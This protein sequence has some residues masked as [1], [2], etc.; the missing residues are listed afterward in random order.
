M[1]VKASYHHVQ[2]LTLRVAKYVNA[3]KKDAWHLCQQSFVHGSKTVKTTSNAFV[4]SS[5][6]CLTNQNDFLY[7][8]SIICVYSTITY[9]RLASGNKELHDIPANP[10]VCDQEAAA[11]LT[12]VKWLQLAC[13]RVLQIS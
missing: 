4:L 2:I 6:V 12:A 9:F 5:S 11:M 8:Y 1:Y 13:L 3:E 7:R 10:V